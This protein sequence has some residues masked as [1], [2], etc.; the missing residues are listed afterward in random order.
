MSCSDR[1]FRQFRHRPA[2]PGR[3]TG[4]RRHRRRGLPR[5]MKPGR[6]ALRPAK[7]ESTSPLVARSSHALRAESRSEPCF[8]QSVPLIEQERQCQ[9]AARIASDTQAVC[10]SEVGSV[11]C[12]DAAAI[13]RP[14]GLGLAAADRSE[15]RRDRPALGCCCDSESDRRGVLSARGRTVV[16]GDEMLVARWKRGAT[17]GESRWSADRVACPGSSRAPLAWWR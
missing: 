12:C 2:S 7:F 4:R 13:R 5:F 6:A 17:H 11:D 8:H 3:R 1:R 15:R 9:A 10:W 14:R 16:D